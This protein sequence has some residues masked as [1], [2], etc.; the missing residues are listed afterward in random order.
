MI[1]SLL[2][3]IAGAVAMR[4]L[5][6]GL[7]ITPNYYTWKHTEYTAL[8]ILTD[9]HVQQLTANEILRLVYEEAD[10]EEEYNKVKTVIE[11]KYNSLINNSLNNLKANLPYRVQYNSV[12]EATEQYLA[13]Q[14]E[15]RDGRQ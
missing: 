2:I 11:Q 10:K 9:L 6:W 15:K 3:F 8:Q 14:K 4:L 12:K 7:H 1:A 5:Q 13:K